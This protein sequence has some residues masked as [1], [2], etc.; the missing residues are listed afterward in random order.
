MTPIKITDRLVK[1]LAPLQFGPPVHTVYNPLVY[2][3]APYDLYLKRYA[4]GPKE[5]MFVGM[6]PGPWGMAQ[7]GVPFGEVAFARNWLKLE[8]KVN[9]PAIE[10]PKRPVTGFACTRSE[11]SGSRVWGWVRD[12]FET[13]ERFFERFFIANYCPLVFM[14][15]SGLNR[16]PDKL[17]RAERDP[18]FAACDEALRSLVENLKPRLV[19]GVGNFAEKRA[20]DALE[21]LDVQIGRILHP[22]PASPLANR[23]WPGVM[24]VELRALGV[25]W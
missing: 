14:E 3:R 17:P 9:K 23:G 20:L 11:V 8:A 16:T 13:P 15:P 1:R 2:A 6:N 21:G 5:V 4:Q 25:Q 24:E 19:V 7:T 10:H 12:T 18:L 22:S